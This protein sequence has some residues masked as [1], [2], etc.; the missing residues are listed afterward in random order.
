LASVRQDL[1]AAVRNQKLEAYVREL[2]EAAE[3]TIAE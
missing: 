2:R 1:E 3:V